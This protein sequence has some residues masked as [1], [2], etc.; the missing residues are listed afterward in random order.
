MLLVLAL[1]LYGGVG[2]GLLSSCK[3]KRAIV[4]KS[5]SV[6]I[7]NVCLSDS[8][9]S[10]VSFVFDEMLIRT[11]SPALPRYGEGDSVQSLRMENSAGKKVPVVIRDVRVV[12]GR[13][14]KTTK[15]VKKK[16]VCDTLNVSSEKHT[17][18]LSP[19]PKPNC[20][21]IVGMLIGVVIII[22]ASRVRS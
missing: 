1:I 2:G 8:I 21:F 15:Q 9:R 16:Q 20:W 11:L 6:A 3:T 13:I 14:E 4:E 17:T 10:D 18:P 12:N 19:P 7:H 5:D 22:F